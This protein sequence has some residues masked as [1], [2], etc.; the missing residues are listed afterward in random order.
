[1]KFACSALW[2]FHFYFD[3]LK[4]FNKGLLFFVTYDYVTELY[5]IYSVETVY[6]DIKEI[7]KK[8]S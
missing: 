8:L 6:N 7:G 5:F 4:R 2:V 3:K 1:M